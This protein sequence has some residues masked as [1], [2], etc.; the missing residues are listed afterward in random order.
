MLVRSLFPT[1]FGAP[2]GLGFFLHLGSRGSRRPKKGREGF[3][4]FPPFNLNTGFKPPQKGG[5]GRMA[6]FT[7]VSQGGSKFPLYPKR[8][9][10]GPTPGKG[11]FRKRKP[12]AVPQEKGISRNLGTTEEKVS[13]FPPPGCNPLCEGGPF[14]WGPEKPQGAKRGPGIPGLKGPRI[15]ISPFPRG[16]SEAEPGP[17]VWE[18]GVI[19]GGR[20][21]KRAFQISPGGKL[22]LEF[23]GPR[24]LF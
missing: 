16:N 15:G 18:K 5:P 12:W 9:P 24:N 7:F 21:H 2:L 20:G 13:I 1:L 17:W 11:C 6:P 4:N 14:S 23:K 3:Q 10:R 19:R 8:K 22:N